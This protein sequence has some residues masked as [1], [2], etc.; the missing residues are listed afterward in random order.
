M[1]IVCMLTV[2]QLLELVKPGDWLTTIDLN[3]AYLHIEVAQALSADVW[4]RH[5]S[6]CATRVCRS[7]PQ[8][9][10]FNDQL[11]RVDSTPNR[12]GVC[13]QLML[14]YVTR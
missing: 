2:K 9:P 5:F 7:F 1:H 13:D 3:N 10:Y 12:A 4:M 14:L 6:F 8:Q 11:Q